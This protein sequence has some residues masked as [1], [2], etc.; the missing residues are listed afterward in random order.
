MDT[1]GPSVSTFRRPIICLVTDR[2]RLAPGAGAEAQVDALVAQVAEAARAGADLVQV[3]E[4]DLD[5]AALLSLAR[6]GVDVTRGSRT[7]VVINDRV[8]VALAA[9][10][11][12]VHLR[13]D[14]IEPRRARALVPGGWTIGRSVHAAGEAA[15]AGAAVDYLVFGAVFP[16]GSKTPGHSIAG[17][18][19]LA[20]AAARGSAPVLAIGGVTVDRLAEVF[21]A[22]A[23]GVAAIGLFLP[24]DPSDPARLGPSAAIA[25]IR[26]AFDTFRSLR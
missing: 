25:A 15:R 6:R 3:R 18:A 10:A 4:R 19:A 21:A 5:A 16:T 14:S 9:G 17:L 8:D 24:P 7:R 1:D 13:A 11:D 22:G 20:D 23:A 2:R 26:H 12:G